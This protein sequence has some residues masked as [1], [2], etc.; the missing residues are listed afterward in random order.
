[1]DALADVRLAVGKVGE[2][3][4]PSHQAVVQDA[5]VAGGQAG[6]GGDGGVER[7][8][9]ADVGD[10]A[11]TQ[12]GQA[13]HD[14]AGDVSPDAVLVTQVQ[15]APPVVLGA[16]PGV[17]VARRPG[18]GIGEV[19]QAPAED[20]EVVARRVQVQPVYSRRAGA[21]IGQL[22]ADLAV[23]AADQAQ[24][25]R[26]DQHVMAD[27]VR[28]GEALDDQAV[29]LHLGGGPLPVEQLVILLVRRHHTGPVVGAG[30]ADTCPVALAEQVVGLDLQVAA[31][32]RHAHRVPVH[33]D[34][35]SP[36][37]ALLRRQG[38][39]RAALTLIG[40]PAASRTAWML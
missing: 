15:H 27:V 37:R 8:D 17:P 5:G 7:A 33:I 25:G 11:G 4:P 9:L 3:I 16:L 39:H 36:Q 24:V 38:G 12:C 1:M 40:H 6:V 19:R 29:A 32:A 23:V 31:Q 18:G 21:L 13:G 34:R 22:V 10:A 26:D 20:D 35:R 2:D 14:A 30:H 28:A